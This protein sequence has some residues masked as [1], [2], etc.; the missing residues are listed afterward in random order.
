YNESHNIG[1]RI[2][3][4]PFEDLYYNMCMLLPT[5]AL[6]EYFHKKSATKKAAL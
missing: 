1:F 5:V 4:I 3:T 6:F 2:G